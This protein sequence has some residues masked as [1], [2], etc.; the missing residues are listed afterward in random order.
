MKTIIAIFINLSWLFIFCIIGCSSPSTEEQKEEQLQPLDGEKKGISATLGQPIEKGVGF[1]II[2]Q[3]SAYNR[4]NFRTGYIA[5]RGRV[6]R[7][8]NHSFEHIL[9]HEKRNSRL[10]DTVDT[11]HNI[12]TV[13]YDIYEMKIKDNNRDTTIHAEIARNLREIRP[14]PSGLELLPEIKVLIDLIREERKGIQSHSSKAI[15]PRPSSLFINRQNSRTNNMPMPKEKY[16]WGHISTEDHI[17]FSGSS[18]YHK[19]SLF[20]NTLNNEF[21]RD[22]DIKYKDSSMRF[23]G[24][25]I[26]ITVD[27]EK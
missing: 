4:G 9:F 23:Q 5:F 24:A 25:D 7:P 12:Y 8:L 19:V 21:A 6:D 27:I 11:H 22:D 26:D 3:D 16:T 10:P 1:G 13:T 17:T 18:D 15:D 20:L 14:V 2:Y